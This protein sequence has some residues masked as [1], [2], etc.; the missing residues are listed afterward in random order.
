[1]PGIGQVPRNVALVCQWTW[2]CVAPPR[3]PD[4]HANEAGYGVIARTFLQAAG[5]S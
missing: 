4:Q 5:L 3:G 2:E 1:M